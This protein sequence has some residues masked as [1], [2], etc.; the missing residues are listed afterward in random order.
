M[1]QAKVVDALTNRA[2]NGVDPLATGHVSPKTHADQTACLRDHGHGPITDVALT[3]CFARP[4]SPA[5]RPR[6]SARGRA[7]QAVPP[8]RLGIE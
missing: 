3:R 7:A 6:R 1:I 5:T 8:D 4:R 2:H